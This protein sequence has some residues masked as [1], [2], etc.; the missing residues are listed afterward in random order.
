MGVWQKLQTAAF[1]LKNEGPRVLVS[2]LIH[3]VRAA[4]RPVGADE[5]EIIFALLRADKRV[6]VMIDVG[7]H[8]GSSLYPFALNGWTVY[9]IE[10]DSRNRAR[11]THRVGKLSNVIVDPRGVSDRPQSSVTLFRSQQSSGISALRAFHPSHLPGEEIQVTTLA[12]LV[13]ER[14]VTEVDFLKVDTEGLDL[15]V[16][17]G[18][19]WDQLTPSVVVCEFEDSKTTPLGYSFQDLAQ[20]VVDRGYRVVVSEWYPIEQYGE[21]H[22]WRCFATY[23]CDLCAAAAW[24]NIIAVREELF[25]DLLSLTG[26]SPE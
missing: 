7:A 24:G 13:K 18:F 21:T 26:L 22:S 1:I 19:P 11:L 9:A 15:M 5:I 4:S 25:V 10:P 17:R 12:Q 8:F 14:G 3:Q 16:L 6:G 2:E 23:P 20:F